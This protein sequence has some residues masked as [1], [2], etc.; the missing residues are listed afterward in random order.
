MTKQSYKLTKHQQIN[1]KQNSVALINVILLLAIMIIFGGPGLS[2]KLS[3]HN[4]QNSSNV[5]Q[6]SQNEYLR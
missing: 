3:T 5:I 4:I 2:P 6:Y 1:S